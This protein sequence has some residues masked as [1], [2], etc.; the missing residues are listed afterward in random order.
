MQ[1]RPSSSSTEFIAALQVLVCL[2]GFV[3]GSGSAATALFHKERQF[4]GMQVRS[5]LVLGLG[6]QLFK[7]EHCFIQQQHRDTC[8]AGVTSWQQA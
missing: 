5:T 2:A 3:A 6:T 4:S 8:F 1:Y 7:I